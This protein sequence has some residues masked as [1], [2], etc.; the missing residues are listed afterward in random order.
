[1]L[2]QSSVLNC[3][4]VAI[5]VWLK[6]ITFSFF[7]VPLLIKIHHL[8]HLDYP[9]SQ[10]PLRV[11]IKFHYTKGI[12]Y[13]T[14]LLLFFFL[15][16]QCTKYIVLLLVVEIFD[17]RFLTDLVVSWSQEIASSS[18]SFLIKHD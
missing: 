16:T 12:D 17:I 4:F 13:F 10:F 3:E 9:C 14:T 6:G 8:G 7:F 5:S 1:M 18:L 2:L 15:L 11:D